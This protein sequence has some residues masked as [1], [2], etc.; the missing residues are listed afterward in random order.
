MPVSVRHYSDP[1]CPWSWG[2]EPALRRL[3]WEFGDQLEFVWVM[4]GLAREYGAEY[5]DSVGAIGTGVDCFSDL[6]TQWLDVADQTGMPFDPRIWTTNPLS[7]TYPAC[8]AVKAA[9]EQGSD[10]THRYLRRLREGLMVGRRKLDHAEALLAEAGPAGLDRQRFEIDLHSHAIT[11]AFAAD[12]DEVRDVPDEAREADAVGT[13]E[14]KERVTFPSLV[15]VGET[16]S[17]HP[18]WGPQA[19]D[20]YRDAAMAAGAQAQTEQAPDPLAVVERFGTAA[21][22]EVE[23]VC[24]QPRPV[25]EAQLWELAREWKLKPIPA[26]TGTMWELA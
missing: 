7:G 11:E 2:T 22:R 16:G 23:E 18:V 14:G 19:Y 13:T 10:A 6:I 8:Q 4:G 5:S 15:F 25:V 20:A 21:T 3:I 9:G 1:A 26:L 24:R 12:L 17:R